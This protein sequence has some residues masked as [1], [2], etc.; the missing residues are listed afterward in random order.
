MFCGL[1]RVVRVHRVAVVLTRV[2]EPVEVVLSGPAGGKFVQGSGGP[3]IEV[4]A[5]E[6]CR[7]LSGCAPGGGLLE[8]K[9]FF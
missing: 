7:V 5:L 9:I 4:D 6:L 3:R 2:S 1:Q 8:T